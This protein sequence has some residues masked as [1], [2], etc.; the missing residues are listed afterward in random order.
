MLAKLVGKAVFTEKPV[1][2]C[3]CSLS[4]L[5][6]RSLFQKF[7]STLITPRSKNGKEGSSRAEKAGNPSSPKEHARKKR[8]ITALF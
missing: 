3:C 5:L 6:N 2:K 7:E 1:V 8:Q 4:V